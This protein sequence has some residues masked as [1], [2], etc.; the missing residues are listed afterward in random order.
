MTAFNAIAVTTPSYSGSESDFPIANAVLAQIAQSV[1]QLVGSGQARLIDLRGV[2]R[3]RDAEYRYLK[4]T[5]A[6][7][8]VSA[9]VDTDS[10]VEVSETQYAGVWW[11]THRGEHGNIVTEI[12]EITDIPAII[13]PHAADLRDGLRRL[14]RLILETAQN[15]G[16]QRPGVAER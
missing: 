3:M 16:V 1:A 14:E 15:G 9:V 8:E 12:V 7:G 10:R 2:P 13:K 6:T 5:L 4:D 11:V